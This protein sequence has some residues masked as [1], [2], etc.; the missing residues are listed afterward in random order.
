MLIASCKVPG[1]VTT[2]SVASVGA[3]EKLA[4]RAHRVA[5]SAEN[6]VDYLG[7]DSVVGQYGHL[8]AGEDSVSL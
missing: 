1:L 7:E 6:S 2:D 5:V 8:Q 3:F 4:E